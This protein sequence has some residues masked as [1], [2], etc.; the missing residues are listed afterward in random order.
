VAK[1]ARLD[2]LGAQRLLEQAI[3][4]QVDL[5]RGQE[6]RRPA[7]ARDLRQRIFLHHTALL[8]AI[9]RHLLSVTRA[10]ALITPARCVGAAG[11]GP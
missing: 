8:C 5:R 6:V 11:S 10:D 1:Q 3:V 2:V 4:L 9:D 7:V